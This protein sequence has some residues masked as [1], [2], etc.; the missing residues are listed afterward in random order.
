MIYRFF[1]DPATAMK[2]NLDGAQTN[3]NKVCR[4]ISVFAHSSF[5]GEMRTAALTMGLNPGLLRTG[6]V[7]ALRSD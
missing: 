5:H 4:P 1:L 2:P 6:Q 7:L 3:P